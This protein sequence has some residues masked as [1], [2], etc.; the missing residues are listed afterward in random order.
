[1]Q[2]VASQWVIHRDPRWYHRPDDFLPQR[3]DGDLA[4]QLPKFAYFPFGGGPRRCIGDEFAKMEAALILA[5]IA[6]RFKLSLIP[7]QQIDYFPSITLRPKYGIRVK[8]ERR[9]EGV[10]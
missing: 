9:G 4:R 2:V 6:R 7:N 5:A 1:M 10:R 3:W 8:V